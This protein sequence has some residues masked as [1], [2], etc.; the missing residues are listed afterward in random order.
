MLAAVG[1]PEPVLPP[2]DLAK[3]EPFDFEPD[4]ERLIEKKLAERAKQAEEA[5][6][7][8]A[9]R[10]VEAAKKAEGAQSPPASE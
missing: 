10:Q 7:R 1:E 4:V 9:A 3:V 5:A 8:D 2:F 6:K